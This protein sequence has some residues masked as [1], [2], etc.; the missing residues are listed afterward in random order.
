M[1]KL[2]RLTGGDIWYNP[3]L[4]ITIVVN[5][6]GSDIVDASGVLK[7]VQESPASIVALIGNFHKTLNDL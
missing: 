1:I 7:S 3:N 5:G 2:T 4:I 6:T